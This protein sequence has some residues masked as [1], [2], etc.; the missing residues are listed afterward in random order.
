MTLKGFFYN[1]GAKFNQVYR[2]LDIKEDFNDSPLDLTH[3]TIEQYSELA[4]LILKHCP[5][6]KEPFLWNG[7]V[8]RWTDLQEPR[9]DSNTHVFGE[10]WI[11]EGIPKKFTFKMSGDRH[12]EFIRGEY[13][14][15]FI[16]HNK[17]QLYSYLK[18]FRLIYKTV[19]QRILICCQRTSSQISDLWS[20]QKRTSSTNYLFMLKHLKPM[21][22]LKWCLTYIL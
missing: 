9:Y 18:D 13:S 22:Y 21:L 10:D 6:P 7:N 5:K 16:W 12:D 2:S 19:L 1:Q 17:I 15:V 8:H 4:K 20:Y 11:F 14:S 3:C